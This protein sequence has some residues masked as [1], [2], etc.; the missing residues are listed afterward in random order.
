MKV[1]TMSFALI[2]AAL[3]TGC[4][5]QGTISNTNQS[6]QPQIIYQGDSPEA[7]RYEAHAA[8]LKAAWE[9]KAPT[10][11]LLCD[12]RFEKKTY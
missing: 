2:A 4:S 6:Q 10:R 8:C 11:A 5:G 3:V 1:F 9:T 7:A 12:E